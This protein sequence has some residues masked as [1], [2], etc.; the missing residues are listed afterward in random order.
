M[1]VWEMT[2]Q[3]RDDE[4]AEIIDRDKA[5]L[6]TPLL[7]EGNVSLYQLSRLSARQQKKREKNVCIKF[8][9]ESRIKALRNPED[10]RGYF[11]RT[12]TKRLLSSIG[13]NESHIRFMKSIGIGKRGKIKPTY[14][15]VIDEYQQKIDEAKSALILI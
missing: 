10:E 14:Q 11:T 4:I 6:A 8:A 5:A 9:A 15:R 3:Q 7:M 1:H 13:S 12:E 2:K